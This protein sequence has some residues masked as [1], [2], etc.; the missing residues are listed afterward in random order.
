MLNGQSDRG[1]FWS[2]YLNLFWKGY[3]CISVLYVYISKHY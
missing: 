1:G 3:Y 2:V